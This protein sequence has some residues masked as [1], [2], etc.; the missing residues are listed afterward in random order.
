MKQL[1]A[2]KYFLFQKKKKKKKRI[3]FY[4]RTPVPS[5]DTM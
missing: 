1:S 5:F 4:V 2:L 3:I